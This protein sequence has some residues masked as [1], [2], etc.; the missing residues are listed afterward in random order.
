MRGQV[1]RLTVLCD[2][3]RLSVPGGRPVN[4]DIPTIEC[5]SS[6]VSLMGRFML[7]AVIDLMKPAQHPA[8]DLGQL[9]NRKRK[10]YGTLNT[11]WRTGCSG[12]TSST[13]SAPLYAIRRAS[14]LG[15][16]PRRLH[17]NAR[18]C[19]PWQLSQRT[20]RNPRSRRPHSR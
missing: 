3:C 11:H 8:Y 15:Q 16:K 14:Q 12:K 7:I 6:Q 18:R 10:G 1:Q 5:R 2:Y 9:A 20:R 17:E 13:R 19:S 4:G